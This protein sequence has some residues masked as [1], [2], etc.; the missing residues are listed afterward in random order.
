MKAVMRLASVALM[1]LALALL[2]AVVAYDPTPARV[3]VAALCC[4]VAGFYLGRNRG[5][6]R[7]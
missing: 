4:T 1:I 7:H 5:P 2:V 3:L 6:G